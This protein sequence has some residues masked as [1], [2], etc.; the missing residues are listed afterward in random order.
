VKTNDGENIVP[1]HDGHSHIHALYWHGEEQ[2]E[3]DDLS[4]LPSAAGD[5]VA[6]YIAWNDMHQI[7][8]RGNDGHIHEIWWRGQE[9]ASN[10]DLTAAAVGAPPASSD[11]AAYYSAGTDTKHVFYR[12]IDGHL[13]EIWWDSAVSPAHVDITVQA[14]AP[15]AG[16]KP[17]AF[18]VEG[19]NTHH[20]VYRGT[21]NEIY[22]ICWA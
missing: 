9:S 5:P 17:T 6:Y 19:P 2:V 4:T 22:E 16:G 11:P 7:A 14:R 3:H 1:Y 18:T 20:V 15:L 8:Y 21:D 10:W 12:G 13:H